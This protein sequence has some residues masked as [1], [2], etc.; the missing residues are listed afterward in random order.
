MCHYTYIYYKSYRSIYTF[1]YSKANNQL[2]HENM[3]MTRSYSCIATIHYFLLLIEQL[4]NL[5][6]YLETRLNIFRFTRN[7]L[8][9]GPTSSFTSTSGR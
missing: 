5:H 2:L 1:I 3:S 4:P 9:V 6:K 7:I 8:A